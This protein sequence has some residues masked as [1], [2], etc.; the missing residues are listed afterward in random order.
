MFNS[1]SNNNNNNITI[2][3]YINMSYNSI[4]TG[5]FDVSLP[6]RALDGR[7]DDLLRRL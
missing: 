6:R 2:N 7:L 1:S 5:A 3:M 4:Q